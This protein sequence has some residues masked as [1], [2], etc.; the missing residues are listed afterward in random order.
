MKYCDLHTHS[1]YSDG[2]YTPSEIVSLAKSKGLCAIALTDHNT[3]DGLAEFEREAKAQ[4]IEYILGSEL[5]CEYSGKEVH[6]HC[7]FIDLNNT[8]GID[9]F[10]KTVR[11]NKKE[12]NIELAKRLR[13]DGYEIDFFELEQKHGKNVNRS[14]FANRLVEKGYVKSIEEAF[15]TL[16]KEGG[17]YYDGSVRPDAI[18]TVRQIV[19]WGCVPVLAHPALSLD[20]NEIRE[21]VEQASKVGLVG[22]EVDHPSHIKYDFPI[23]EGLIEKYKLVRSGGSDFHG[24][25]KSTRELGAPRVSY[26]CYEQLKEAHNKL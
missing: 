18:D 13:A 9:D 11:K 24:D 5:T 14:H 12:R 26:L 17:K 8:Q 19:S 20:Y 3:I 22:I 6:M 25:F 7:M 1:I 15:D 10:T 16:L 4:G 21:F 2:S 23:L